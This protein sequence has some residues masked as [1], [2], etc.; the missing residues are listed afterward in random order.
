MISLSQ[1][2]ASS[3]L[4][5]VVRA[6]PIDPMIRIAGLLLQRPVFLVLCATA[7]LW[8]AG[9]R[10][11]ATLFC[12]FLILS[13]VAQAAERFTGPWDL[14]ALHKAPEAVWGQRTN[15]G[16]EVNYEGEPFQGKPTRICADYGRP[17]QV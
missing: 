11:R 17:N 5:P 4:G 1:I 2:A 3:Y 16:Q 12:V 6:N 15:L 7:Q 8:R 14:S 13:A 9:R 10:R